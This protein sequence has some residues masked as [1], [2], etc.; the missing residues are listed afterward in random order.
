MINSEMKDIL[1]KKIWLLTA[2]PVDA[3]RGLWQVP[4]SFSGVSPD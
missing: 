1:Q 3:A 2:L 4:V